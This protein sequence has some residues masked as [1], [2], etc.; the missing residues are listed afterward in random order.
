MNLAAKLRP[1]SLKEFL[2]QPDIVGQQGIVNKMLNCD[3]LSSLIFW[4]PPATGKTTLANIIAKSTKSEFY[5]LSAVMDGKADLKKILE[6]AEQKKKEKLKSIL[7]IDEIHRWNKSQQDTLLPYVEDSTIVLI[8]A[9]T[10]NPSFSIISALLSRVRVLVFEAHSEENILVALNKG[11]N[12]LNKESKI[13]KTTSEEVKKKIA[14]MADG[15]IRFALTTLEITYQL[16]KKELNLEGV[17]KASQRSLIYDKNGEEHYNL[18]SALHKSLRSSNPSAGTYWL[19]R[20]LT[21][22][23]DPLYIARR[24]IRFAS[25]DIG[26]KNPNALLLANQTYQACQN[27]GMPECDVCLVQLVEYLAKSPKNNSNYIALK[28]AKKDILEFGSLPVPLHLRNAP[29]KLMKDLN[30]AKNYEYDHDLK[31]KKSKQQLFPDKLKNRN[32]Y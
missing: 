12:L 1:M 2:G 22:G 14:Q 17:K 21:A 32:Y 10:E 7:F 3:R 13:N 16:A 24:L 23:E 28:L 5:K 26:N 8:G 30:Y 11:L 15:D 6:K 27:I 18:I 29:T 25:E 4:G 19:M 9:T 20:M 31:T